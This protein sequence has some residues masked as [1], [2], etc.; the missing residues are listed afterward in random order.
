MK[1][2]ALLVP[3]FSALFVSSCSKASAA[4]YDL[5]ICDDAYLSIVKGLARSFDYA[6]VRNTASGRD[7]E[8]AGEKCKTAKQR[9]VCLKAVESTTATTGWNNGSHGRRPGYNYAVVTRGDEVIAV[10]PDN[11]ASVLAPIDSPV[12]ATLVATVQRGVGAKCEGAVR[13]VKGRYEVHLVSDSCFG[14]VD[15]VV[16][17]DA[18]GALEIVSSSHGPGRCVGQLPRAAHPVL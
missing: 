16:L 3:V 1:P 12:K 8:T 13:S 10:T 5:K 15:E 4:S 9:E 14:S 7:V 11:V 17:I 2:L 6:E 18:K